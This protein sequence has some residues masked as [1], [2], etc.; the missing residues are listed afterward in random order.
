MSSADSVAQ[1]TLD[2]FGN[3]RIG[4]AK[5]V[6]LATTGNA[7]V[8]IPILSGGLTN[9]GA[10]VGSGSVIVRR[11][12]VQNPTGNVAAANVAISISNTGNVA[13]ANAVVGNVTLSNLT[14]AGTYQ[15][16]TVAGGFAANT[17]VNGN[18]TQCLY[19]NINTGS[20]NGTV[21]IAVY[22]DVVSF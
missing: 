15:D 9:A 5:T 3:G 20:S 14:G 21:D 22:G 18:L 2:S 13:T 4:V 11:V 12:T 17:V 10:V 8:T 19:V 6:S 16:L 7:V 1:L